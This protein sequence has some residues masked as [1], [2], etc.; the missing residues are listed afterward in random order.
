M[1]EGFTLIAEIF[2]KK[3]KEE[4]HDKRKTEEIQQKAF[5]T[6]VQTKKQKSFG[7]DND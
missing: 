7:S 3:I 6:F 5:E 1:R 2:V 4:E